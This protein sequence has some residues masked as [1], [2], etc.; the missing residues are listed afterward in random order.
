MTFH[1]SNF[2]FVFFYVTGQ[3]SDENNSDGNVSIDIKGNNR[4]GDVNCISSDAP[5][6]GTLTNQ[7]TQLSLATVT[8]QTNDQQSAQQHS[9]IIL[10]RGARTE[11]GQIILQNSHELLSLLNGGGGSGVITGDE[12]KQILLQH[13]RFKTKSTNEST[14]RIL[15]QS[16]LKGATS[17]P[18][19]LIEAGTSVRTTAG[20]T[21]LLQ[22][23]SFKKSNSVT[24]IATTNTTNTTIP[25]G[26][27]ILQ[28]RLNKNGTTEVPILLQTLKRLDKSQSILVFRNP[29][30]ANATLTTN[31][32]VK[33]TAANHITL[34][35]SKDD[36]KLETRTQ[37]TNKSVSSNIP[38]GTG[39]WLTF[40]YLLFSFSS[41][42][43]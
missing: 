41:F 9:N 12:D 25:E 42:S 5:T 37:S 7:P 13:P 20:N 1:N 15:I 35:T 43:V 4:N 26:S 3:P 34:L 30:S 21:V 8:T 17:S 10:I 19:Q 6:D 18:N 33:T 31:T 23:G 28:Q 32:T 16:T 2:F 11:N 22:P 27:I 14:G 38:L 39:K 40:I 24:G 36:D 29:Q